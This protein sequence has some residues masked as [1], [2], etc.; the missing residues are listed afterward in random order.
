MKL[1]AQHPYSA[2][3][4]A[5]W[6]ML[7]DRT[8]RDDV[9]MRTGASSCDVRID[10]DESGGTVSITRVLPSVMSQTMRKLVGDT[11]TV[12]ET[13]TWGPTDGAGLRTATIRLEVRGQPASMQGSRTLSPT[14]ATSVL[15]TDGELKVS[16]PFLGGKL[17][18]DVGKAV[19]AGLAKEHEVGQDYLARR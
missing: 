5:V 8:F 4:D 3:T 6:A 17:E 2:S 11:V 13:E 16:I 15:D 12:I 14:G 18:K 1:T 19:A 7:T 9:C 10:A